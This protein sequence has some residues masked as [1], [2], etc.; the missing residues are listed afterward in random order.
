LIRGLSALVLGLAFASSPAAA[1]SVGL[2][3]ISGNILWETCSP[4]QHDTNNWLCMGYITG[5]TDAVEAQNGS[6]MGR[7]VC[8]QSQVTPGQIVDVVV[9][10]L[11]Q[12]PEIREYAAPGLIAG[13]LAKAFPCS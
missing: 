11:G 8:I 12:H 2:N 3:Y 1:Q 9:Q 6:F 13:A 4:S 7:R 10:F 5:I